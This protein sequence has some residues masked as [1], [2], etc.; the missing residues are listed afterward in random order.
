[1]G[2]LSTRRQCRVRAWALVGLGAALAQPS[3]A[4]Q[5]RYLDPVFPAVNVTPDLEFASAHDLSG[6][7]WV[8]ELDVYQPSGDAET[9]RP[10]VVVVHGGGFLSGHKAMPN[11]VD[12]A[13]RMAQRGYV[14]ISINYRLAKNNAEKIAH[15]AEIV[16]NAKEDFQAAVSFVRENATA[17]G[18]DSTRVSTMGAS[19]GATT[20]LEGTY[21]NEV[22][23]PANSSEVQACVDMWGILNSLP[24]MEAGDAPVCIVH[25][26][27][28]GTVPFQHAKDLKAQADLVGVPYA[29]HPIA[30]FGH[31]P[32]TEFWANYFEPCL[33]F[34][35]QYLE[36]GKLSALVLGPGP[37]SPGTLVLDSSGMAGDLRILGVGLPAP[38]DGYP[39]GIL[40]TLHLD[41]GTLAFVSIPSFPGTEGI[42]TDYAAY[43]VPSGLGGVTIA[44]QELH[45]EATGELR[46]LTNHVE[47]AF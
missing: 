26:T 3:A 40:G 18:V 44:L 13:T 2:A 41:P 47:A 29:W 19:A 8:L 27:M 45:I 20:N 22:P 24:A 31:A 1:M 25:G 11:Y 34:L 30:G 17:W 37:T 7:L 38:G 42:E 9:S 46:L 6:N 32:W 43:P 14:A 36:L 4:Q 10:A 5:T 21:V 35:Y 16:E 12:L 23:A 33:E 39:F 28:D 15:Y